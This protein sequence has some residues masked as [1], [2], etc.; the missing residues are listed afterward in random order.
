MSSKF[1]KVKSSSI[2]G[3]NYNE[4]ERTLHVQWKNGAV[5]VYHHVQPK[6][7]TAFMTAESKR[8]YLNDNIH[9]SHQ[10]RKMIGTKK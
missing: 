1:E 2:E 10:L 3:V 9:G 6:T 7:Y 8:G 5:Y 4:Q